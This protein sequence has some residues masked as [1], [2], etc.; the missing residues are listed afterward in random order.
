MEPRL[1]QGFTVS[2]SSER[3]DCTPAL[4]KRFT[5]NAGL[6]FSFT[7][8]YFQLKKLSAEQK[9]EAIQERRGAYT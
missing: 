6:S 4:P 1:A 5:D 2:F 3:S 9:K 8:R 7:A